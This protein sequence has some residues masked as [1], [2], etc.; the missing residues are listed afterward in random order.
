MCAVTALDVC[1]N[2][3]QHPRAR[4]RSKAVRI[5]ALLV[6]TVNVTWGAQHMVSVASLGSVVQ[7]MAACPLRRVLRRERAARGGG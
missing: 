1:V 3:S 4:S 7:G 6:V 2:Q 5:A